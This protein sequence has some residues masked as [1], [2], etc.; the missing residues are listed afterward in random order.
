MTNQ[1]T[2]LTIDDLSLLYPDQVFL[3]FDTTIKERVWQEIQ[4]QSYPTDAARQNA[5]LNQLLVRSFLGYLNTD[6]LPDFDQDIPCLPTIWPSFSARP[7]VW[8]WVSGSAIDIGPSRLVLIPTEDIHGDDVRIPR[9]WVELPEW[10]GNFYL[11]AQVDIESGWIQVLGYATH[12][13]LLQQSHYAAVDETYQ[14]STD[15]L[16]DNLAPLWMTYELCQTPRPT[17]STMEMA[18]SMVARANP[19]QPYEQWVSHL[20]FT[21]FTLQRLTLPFGDWAKVVGTADGRRLLHTH[22]MNASSHASSTQAQIHNLRQWLKNRFD[23]GWHALDTLLAHAD[24]RLAMSF[25]G[26]APAHELTVEGVKLIDLGV[27][28]GHQQ[29]ALII[30]LFEESDQRIV[31]RVQLLPTQGVSYL[32]PSLTLRLM[33]QSDKVLQTLTARTNDN[34]MQLKRF[35]CKEGTQFTIQLILE[36]VELTETFAVKHV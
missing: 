16:T 18:H 32:P 3:E 14:L 24:H 2:N 33:S 21:S 31:V 15:Q 13:Q 10:M 9:E 27:Q 12:A 5:Y 36:G 23:A 34:L 8:S 7:T 4:R 20:A 11:A 35:T 1:P 26:L 17:G 22:L 25:R 6:V 29:M 30:G 19:R 28:L